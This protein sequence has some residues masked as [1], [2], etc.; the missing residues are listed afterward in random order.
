VPANGVRESLTVPVH[1][2][3]DRG[4]LQPYIVRHRATSWKLNYAHTSTRTEVRRSC[5]A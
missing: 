2:E 5:P 1:D 3:L 4:T